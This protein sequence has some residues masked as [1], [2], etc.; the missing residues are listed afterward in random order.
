MGQFLGDGNSLCPYCGG[1]FL[2]IHIFICLSKPVKANTSCLCVC[3]MW[4]M[5]WFLKNRHYGH[6]ADRILYLSQGPG[7]V[8]YN[9][10]RYS[11]LTMVS[12]LTICRHMALK[13]YY[14]LYSPHCTFPAL[15]LTYFTTRR[16]YLLIPF[17]R[18]GSF[19]TPYKF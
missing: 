16:L 3:Y 14:G 6:I 9:S 4:I 13:Q 2:T 5:P 1:H 15:W 8:I 19:V 12:V 18:L 17:T 7:I 11:K 10:T